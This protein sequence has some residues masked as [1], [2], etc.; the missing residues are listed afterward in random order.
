MNW[1]DF[2]IIFIM[3]YNIVR[4]VHLG[5]VRSIFML[6][7]F[8]ASIYI[9]KSCYPIVTGY[10]INTPVVYN[11]FEKIS[12]TI[13]KSA[14]LKGVIDNGVTILIN[15]FSIILLYCLIRWAI[16]LIE[17]FISPLFKVPI[18][19]QL[20]RV[21]GFL[22]GIIKGIMVIYIIFAIIKPIG[23]IFSDGIIASA[24]DSSLLS[25]IFMD[26]NVIDFFN[27]KKLKGGI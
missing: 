17:K 9:T 7:K 1:L 24:I 20:N 13:L 8:L 16:G 11:I 12:N 6:I 14:H 4:N 21:G 23:A 19:R 15:I 3:V 26:F 25:D 27:I 10:I 5:M 2:F 18:L 22:I